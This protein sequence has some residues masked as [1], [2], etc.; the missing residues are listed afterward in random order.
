MTR[1]LNQDKTIDVNYDNLDI[2]IEEL[3]MCDADEDIICDIRASCDNSMRDWILATYPTKERALEVM[4]EIGQQ[5][6]NENYI[7]DTD[8][9]NTCVMI[10]T[11]STYEMPEK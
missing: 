11:H 1:I 2:Y 10:S 5:W 4:A 9:G 6:R 3:D 8:G 7:Q